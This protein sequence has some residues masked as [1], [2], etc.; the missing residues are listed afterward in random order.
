MMNPKAILHVWLPC[1]KI[2]PV[3][4]TYL[5]S[6]IHQKHPEIKQR[7]LDLSLLPR[8][9]RAGELKRTLLEINPDL[10]LFSWRDI[11]VFAPHEGD[12]SLKYAFNFYYSP[13]PVKKLIASIKGLQYLWVYYQNIRETLSYPWLVYKTLPKSRIMMGG[14]AF[15]V[16]SEQLIT[17]L[18]PGT[19]GVVGEGEEA[20]LKMVEDRP[21]A[22][23]RTI[24]ATNGKPR[25]GQKGRYLSLDDLAIDLSYL[26]AIF[27]QH[28]SYHGEFIGVQTKRGCPYDCQFCE[29]PYIEGKK[30]R[31]RPPAL[32]LDEIKQF[33]QQWGVRRFW[34]T[35]AQFFTGKES[36]PQ[37]TEIMERIIAEGL[38]L[39]WSGYIRTSLI[40]SQLAA[41]MVRSGLGDLEVSITSGSQAVVNSLHMGFS[42][43]KLYDGCRYL[44]EAGFQGKLILNYSLNSPGDSEEGL[45]ES[46]A[47][48][49][50]IAAIM[51]EDRVFP[52]LFFLGVQPHTG[53]EQRLIEEGYLYQGYN[54]LS[55][56][57]MTIKKKLYNPKP[58]SQFIAKACLAAW[59]PVAWK[60]ARERGTSVAQ[61]YADESMFRGVV[62]NSG[63]QVLI[64]LEQILKNK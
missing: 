29:Y 54:P 41:L 34:F 45:L 11:Q 26:T 52:M 61:L 40:N 31:Y 50:R 13:N 47:S 14:G 18:P 5:A 39:E 42:L 24:I 12:P 53:F 9:A 10:V 8:P 27:P 21:L 58:L 38:K 23:E 46:V 17:K 19:I 25:I 64:S 28:Q 57:P 36:F 3:G 16:F 62:E 63:K 15:S 43:E 7:L 55:M 44:K 32:V 1:K 49:K 48:Y 51:G 37:C 56:N 20:I 60:H 6:Y 33:Y 22:D 59:D 30:V 35:D 4:L 2:Y